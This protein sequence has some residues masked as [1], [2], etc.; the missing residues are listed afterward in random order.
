MKLNE[1]YS[2]NFKALITIKEASPRRFRAF[3][4]PYI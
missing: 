1:T 2:T 4:K 3:M